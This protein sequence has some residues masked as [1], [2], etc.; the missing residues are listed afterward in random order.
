MN[1][2]TPV[3]EFSFGTP[4]NIMYELTCKNHPKLRWST[5]NPYCRN[6]HYLGAEGD[7]GFVSEDECPC[8]FDD[9][10]V[11]EP[12][13]LITFSDHSA[14]KTNDKEEIELFKK[15]LEQHEDQ[16]DEFSA[17]PVYVTAVVLL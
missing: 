2:T 15:A 3:T 7:V 14:Y 6:L 17:T 1:N 4:S 9:L 11:I 16:T 10:V 8:P 12:Y 5:K 13:R